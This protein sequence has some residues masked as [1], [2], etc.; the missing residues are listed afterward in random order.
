MLTPQSTAEPRRGKRFD[1][2]RGT[3]RRGESDMA[4]DG[5]QCHGRIAAR[6]YHAASL[7]W[8]RSRGGADTTR[9]CRWG[10]APTQVASQQGQRGQ[11]GGVAAAAAQTHGCRRRRCA[12]ETGVSSPQERRRGRGVAAAGAARRQGWRRRS[13]GAERGVSPPQGRRRHTGDVA[14]GVAQ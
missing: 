6:L 3:A 4:A 9:G 12:A 7:G 5:Q 11:T 10:G 1:G 8:R 14:A 13:S 2:L